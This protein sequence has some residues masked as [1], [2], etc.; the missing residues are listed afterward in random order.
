MLT[1]SEQEVS[2]KNDDLSFDLDFLESSPS[3]SSQLKALWE[4]ILSVDGIEADDDFIDLG[5]DSLKLAELHSIVCASFNR[6]FPV[7]PLLSNRTLRSMADFITAYETSEGF[8]KF[9]IQIRPKGKRRPLF[10][11]HDAGGSVG[12]YHELA[13]QIH[14]DIPL[15][16]LRFIPECFDSKQPI[17]V[18]EIAKGYVE[19]IVKVDAIGPYQLAGLSIGGLI[20][21]EMAKILLESGKEVAF[22]GLFDT[23]LNQKHGSEIPIRS[24]RERIRSAFNHL[25]QKNVVDQTKTLFLRG[26]PFITY[27]FKAQKARFHYKYPDKVKSI[28]SEFMNE[29]I[30]RT[31]ARQYEPKYLP[32][33]MVY[34]LAMKED[35]ESSFEAWKR[36]CRQI[37]RVEVDGFH[38]SAIKTGFAET[39]AKQ[40]SE[41][42][43]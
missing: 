24:N 21:F 11:I 41:Y 10:L 12:I 38:S 9:I 6:D 36:L 4:E 25:R 37:V 32:I 27:L 2:G 35:H 18:R 13:K 19:E 23:V 20:A 28:D 30:L 16:G 39:T 43:L 7:L 29:P 5:G 33:R 40:I 14:Q 17:S 15:Y 31:A 42:L 8:Y 3:V 34:F 22:I 26:I 1:V